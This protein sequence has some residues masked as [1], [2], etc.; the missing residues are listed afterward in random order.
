METPPRTIEAEIKAPLTDAG[1]FRGELDLHGAE[2][3]DHRIQEDRYFDHPVRS[4]KETDEALRV[5]ITTG[6]SGCK[7]TY[8]G[9]KLD[10]QTKSRGEIE[11]GVDDTDGITQLLEALGF[12]PV[13]RVSKEREVYQLEGITITVDEVEGLGPYVELEKMVPKEEAEDARKELLGMADQLDL[14]ELERRSY[15][16]LLLEKEDGDE[17]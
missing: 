3:L 9:P 12:E 15:L 10:E 1:T 2:R 14:R 7:L 8:K 4:F 13:A 5:R 11:V 17:S 16:E 6:Q